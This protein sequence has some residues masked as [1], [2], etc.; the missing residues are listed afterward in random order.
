MPVGR[1]LVAFSHAVRRVHYLLRFLGN[2]L[3]IPLVGECE[4][5]G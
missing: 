3:R 5:P 4:A 2:E 1:S